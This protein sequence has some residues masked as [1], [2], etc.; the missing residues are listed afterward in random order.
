MNIINSFNN[1]I[2]ELIPIVQYIL[3]SFHFKIKE[4]WLFF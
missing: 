1:A 2:P 4:V 3:V